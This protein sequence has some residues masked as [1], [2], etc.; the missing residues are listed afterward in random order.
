M[1]HFAV[2]NDSNVVT[3]VN[4]VADA[5]CLDG[6]GNESE[7]V[8]IAFCESLWGSGTYKQT[9]YNNRIRKQYAVVG[10]TYDASANQFVKIQPYASW[11]L[12]SDNDW[13]APIA[14]PS[15]SD[16][17]LYGWNETLYQSDNTKG[18]ESKLITNPS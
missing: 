4:V 3:A 10:G 1:A 6:D 11:T 2:L 12:N 16:S 14:K 8:G 9:S 18:W 5:D 15:D 13:V 17:V 7:A